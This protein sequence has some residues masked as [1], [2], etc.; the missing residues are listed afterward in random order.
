[1][2]KKGFTILELLLYVGILS[3][4]MFSIAFFIQ[5]MM[6]ARLKSQTIAEV[7]QQGQQVMQQI[8]QVIRN[9]NSITAP[10]AGTNGA[11]LTVDVYDAGKDPTIID[12]A[13]NVLRIKEGAGSA[14]PL[15][16]SRVNVSGSS[17]QNLSR[18]STPGTVRIQFTITHVNTSQKNE[19]EYSKTFYG[20]A[21]IRK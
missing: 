12:V 13:S 10:A 21:N 1:M 19:F 15:T 6:S 16:S 7:E 11:S 8:T 4:V 20:S 14:V 9:A 3:A 17:F 2:N 18:A 5:M